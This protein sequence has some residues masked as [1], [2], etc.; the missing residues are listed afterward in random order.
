M[1]LLFSERKS[2]T[3]KEIID[4][5]K[6]HGG[7]YISDNAVQSTDG[8]FTVVSEYKKTDIK[9]KKGIAIFCDGSER[10]KN[11]SFPS[12]ITGI[13]ED[14][15]LEAL[16]LFRQSGIPVISCGINSKNTVT[17]SSINGKALLATLQR[18]VTDSRGSEIEPAEFKIKL[19]KDYTPFSVMACVAVLLVKGIV[20]REF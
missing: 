13:C 20:P 12:G 19:N 3:E 15:N 4:I 5:L 8:L 11:Q 1:V 14:S 16:E 2:R 18:T 17:L 7:D 9:I 10:F 6:A